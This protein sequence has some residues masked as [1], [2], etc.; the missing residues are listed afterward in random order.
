MLECVKYARDWSEIIQFVL[1]ESQ[2]GEN[3]EGVVMGVAA[4]TIWRD[5]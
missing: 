2:G 5:K 4:G 1:K 3:S